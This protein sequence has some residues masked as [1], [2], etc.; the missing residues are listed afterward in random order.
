M[1]FRPTAV[2][3][4]HGTGAHHRDSRTRLLDVSIGLV[5]DLRRDRHERTAEDFCHPFQV[6][7]PYRGLGVWHVGGDDVVADANQ[8]L[9]VRGGESYRMSGPVPGGYAELVITPAIEILS[10]VA[11]ANGAG[12]HGHALFR[13]RYGPATPPLQSLRTSF[14][15]WARGASDVDDLEAEEMVVALLR[16]ALQQD[17]HRVQT[18]GAVTARL[19]RR[20]KEFLESRA[21]HRIRLVDVGRAAGASPAYLTDIFRRVEGVSLHRYLTQLRLAR[22]LEALPHADSLTRLALDVGFSSHSHFSAAFLR[23][24]G[25]TPSAFR[26][27]TRRAACPSAVASVRYRQRRASA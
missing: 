21:S 17:G 15:H 26:E 10:E 14:L 23:A 12:L 19:I 2:W 1:K 22:A 7:L 11:H 24:F 6:C 18:C 8:V 13:R 27:V 4:C 25:C 5:E 16:S 3:L 20:A 9:F